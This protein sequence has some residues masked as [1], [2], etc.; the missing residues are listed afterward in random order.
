MTLEDRQAQQLIAELEHQPRPVPVELTRALNTLEA[1]KSDELH[2][3]RHLTPS[4]RAQREQL[5]RWERRKNP[6]GVDFT[7]GTRR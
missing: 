5:A 6:Q 7:M 3:L 2:A 4:L 1:A